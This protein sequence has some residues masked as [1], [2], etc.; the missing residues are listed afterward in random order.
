MTKR[1]LLQKPVA[2]LGG[3][4]CGQTFAAE[5]SL[6]GH[7][8][9]LYDM[10]EF[11]P[12]SLGKVLENHKIELTGRQINF[13]WFTREGTAN[14]DVVTTDMAEALQGA[15]LIIVAIP[16]KGH[17][18]FFETMIPHLED[19]QVV[20]IFPDNFG[21]LMLKKM[22][23]QQ[24]ANLD[25]LIG[26][27]SSMPYGVRVVE[28]G[29][30][31]CIIRIRE[32]IGDALPSNRGDE[33]LEIMREIPAFDG[34]Q[35][36]KQGDTILGVDLSNPNPLVHVPGSILNVGAME[37]SEMEGAFGIPEGEYSMYKYGMSPAVARV[38]KTFYEEEKKIA[39]EL[40]IE[41]VEYREDQFF[42]K[43]G[44]MGVEF[45]APF[46][47]VTIPP[48][49][50]PT[51]TDH[52]YFSEDIPVGTAVRY[53]LAKALGIDTPMIK[54]ML[55]V[56]S[57]ACNKDFLEEGLSLEDLGLEEMDKEELISYVKT[58]SK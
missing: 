29:K 37:V 46:A 9:R 3:G 18:S 1:D 7:Q 41:M 53:R 49:S 45:W 8:V 39:R 58:G 57:A 25:V 40:G 36:V 50:G 17:T 12:D 34:T 14:I 30:V 28:P 35:K 5:F 26:G 44:V 38:Q 47:D 21:S 52:R 23:D 15:G 51:S 4:A 11:A 32:I 16:A 55:T 6:A 24:N 22:L 42:W 27:W 54:S 10:P 2:V 33:F 19:G 20:S 48:I 43:G 13:N 31:D 56:G